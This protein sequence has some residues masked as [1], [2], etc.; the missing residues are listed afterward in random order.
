MTSALMDNNLIRFTELWIDPSAVEN[1]DAPGAMGYHLPR[2]PLPQSHRPTTLACFVQSLDG[3]FVHPKRPQGPAVARLNVRSAWGSKAD[4]WI[5]QQ[6]RAHVDAVIIGART[7]RLEAA[8]EVLS[9]S[10][11]VWQQWRIAQSGFD[12]EAPF[13]VLLTIDGRDLPLDHPVVQQP[14]NIICTSPKGAAY[15]ADVA[16]MG[17]RIL[18]TGSNTVTDLPEMLAALRERGVRRLS[19]ESPSFFWQMVEAGLLDEL[20][21]NTSAILAGGDFSFGKHQPLSEIPTVH[22]RLLSL[23]LTD[24][25]FLFSR[26][27]FDN[28]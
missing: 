24:P 28:R 11:Q 22:T 14:R 21:L 19:V 20:W 4:W 27:Q 2:L 7:L 6:V 12:S 1:T 18:V 5:L 13:G 23:H 26:W 17:E 15:L 10:N 16:D 8:E 25:Y 9:L 3:K